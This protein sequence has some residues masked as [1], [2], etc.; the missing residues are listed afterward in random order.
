L[1]CYLEQ[2][3]PADADRVRETAREL[4]HL[5]APVAGVV[6]SLG[7]GSQRQRLDHLHGQLRGAGSIRAVGAMLADNLATKLPALPTAWTA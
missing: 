5:P 1:A 6:L 3:D 7:A 2:H 4:W